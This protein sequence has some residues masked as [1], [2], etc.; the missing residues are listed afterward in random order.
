MWIIQMY[1]LLYGLYEVLNKKIYKLHIFCK[2]N[3][4]VSLWEP[5]SLSK[6]V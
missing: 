3:L 2:A 1:S 4:S 5:T 6:Y